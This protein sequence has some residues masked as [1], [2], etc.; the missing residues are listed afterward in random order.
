MILKKIK[1]MNFCVP[2]RAEIQLGAP[3]RH[4]KQHF[5]K[6]RSAHKRPDRH[7]LTQGSVTADTSEAVIALDMRTHSS[8][9]RIGGDGRL[10]LRDR[11]GPLFWRIAHRDDQRD[12][13]VDLRGVAS[14]PRRAKAGQ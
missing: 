8:A 5:K 13:P 7:H 1:R 10:G 4:V 9:W 2:C 14:G 6:C 12:D 11:Q 3:E